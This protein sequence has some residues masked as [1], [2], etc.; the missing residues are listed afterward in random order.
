MSEE[1]KAKRTFSAKAVAI[2]MVMV[3]VLGGVMGGTV[4]WLIDGTDKVVNTFTYGDINIDLEE[5][6]TADGDGNKYTNTY[7]MIPGSTIVK[8]PKLIVTEGSES[9]WLFVELEEVGGAGAWTF[10]DYLEYTVDPIWTKLDGTENVY[11][12][13]Y[14]ANAA[15][16]NTTVPV[17]TGNTVKVKDTVT[18]EMVNALNIDPSNPTYPQL[19]I[20]GYAVQ[21][22]NVDTA[23]TAWGYVN[24]DYAPTE[25]KNSTELVAA[26]ATLKDGDSLLLKAGTYDLTADESIKIQANSVTLVGEG[27][28]NTIINIAGDTFNGQAGM[29]ISGDN[30]TVKNMTVSASGANIDAIKVSEMNNKTDIV[31]NVVLENLVV[32]SADGSGVNLHGVKGVKINNVDCQAYRKV[33]ISLA[34]ATDVVITNCKT[35]STGWADIGCMHGTDAEL[36]ATPSAFEF[37]ETNAFGK[38]VIYSE[39]PSAAAGGADVVTYPTTEWTKTDG[40]DGNWALTKVTVTP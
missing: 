32:K 38:G 5:S 26:L 22:E 11:Y 20:T 21:K 2:L 24:S 34:K 40:T 37:D 23:V 28:A 6:D 31:K 27:A 25:V 15:V 30:V 16:G 33:G 7:E 29:Y 17:L 13:V 3:L 36:Y 8:D 12:I 4:A 18:K 10:D 9:A 39:R 19:M 1:K 14:D 35:L